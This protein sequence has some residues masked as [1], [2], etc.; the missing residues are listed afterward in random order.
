MTERNDRHHGWRSY[1]RGPDGEYVQTASS[2]PEL[3]S[4]TLMEDT[5]AW[6]WTSDMEMYDRQWIYMVHT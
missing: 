1:P 3:P 2:G 5:L 4:L 6:R